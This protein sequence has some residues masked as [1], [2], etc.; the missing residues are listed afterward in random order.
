[1]KVVGTEKVTSTKVKIHTEDLGK[2]SK[3]DDRW[4]GKIPEGTF[5][6][7]S[8]FRLWSWILPTKEIGF[9]LWSVCWETRLWQVRCA[10]HFAVEKD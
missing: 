6:L 1:M 7:V 3:V 8:F 2:I 10:G 5:A 9:G 4:D